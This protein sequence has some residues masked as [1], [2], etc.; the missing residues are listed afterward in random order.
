MKK[1]S[2]SESSSDMMDLE[3][4]VESTTPGLLTATAMGGGGVVVVTAGGD[5]QSRMTGQ[6]LLYNNNSGN[7]NS[8]SNNNDKQQLPQQQ[9]QHSNCKAQPSSG[10][11][12]G[13]TYCSLQR[14]NSA[15]AVSIET[16]V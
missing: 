14:H 16:D 1:S 15:L 3:D 10:F 11:C 2:M 13:S 4:G 8:N 5:P 9:Q 6:P 7:N 12:A